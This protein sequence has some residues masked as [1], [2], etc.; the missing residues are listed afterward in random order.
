MQR[1][2]TCEIC[3]SDSF[4]DQ[5]GKFYCD[6]CGIQSQVSLEVALRKKV[7]M[8]KAYKNILKKEK[9]KQ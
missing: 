4:Y 9:N 8:K 3:D 1:M 7:L 5:D 2:P 6:N